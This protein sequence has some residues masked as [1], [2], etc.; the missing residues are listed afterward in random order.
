[1]F[2]SEV[3]MEAAGGYC[4]IQY[5]HYLLDEWQE[6]LHFEAVPVYTQF[7]RLFKM[8]AVTFMTE[9]ASIKLT[10]FILWSALPPCVPAIVD[11]FYKFTVH[12]LGY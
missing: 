3:F 7:G 2:D 8:K 5:M 12:G 6:Q 10:L 1:V 4:I 9:L 11:S